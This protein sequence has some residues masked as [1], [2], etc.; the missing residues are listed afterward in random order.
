MVLT[1]IGRSHKLSTP[2]CQQVTNP[3]LW[4]IMPEPADPDFA[5]WLESE[6]KKRGWNQSDLANASRQ[7]GYV[8]VAPQISRILSR[9]QQAG[10]DSVIAIAHGL[11]LPREI[12][13]RAR[14]WLPSL[15]ITSPLTVS[16]ALVQE[17]ARKLLDMPTAQREAVCK[18]ILMVLEATSQHIE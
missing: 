4:V 7:R 9:E 17:V 12:V 5:G 2:V 3:C 10:I 6:L 1:S 16:D 8:V 15:P 14:G 11:G 13:F 18:G